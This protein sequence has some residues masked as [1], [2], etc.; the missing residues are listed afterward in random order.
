M[1]SMASVVIVI[2]NNIILLTISLL[3]NCDK[4]YYFYGYSRNFNRKC[5]KNNKLIIFDNKIELSW[6]KGFA[7]ERG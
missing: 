1:V 3:I 7:M 4:Y 2:M 6:Y 5:Y